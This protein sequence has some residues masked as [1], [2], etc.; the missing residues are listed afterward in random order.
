MNKDS[1]SSV[2]GLTAVFVHG[3]TAERENEP[4]YHLKKPAWLKAWLKVDST[5]QEGYGLGHWNA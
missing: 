2:S 4:C 5:G 3:G 1:P